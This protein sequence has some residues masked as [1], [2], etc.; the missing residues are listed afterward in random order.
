[1][2]AV[3]AELCRRN[4]HRYVERAWPL[5]EPGRPFVDNWHIGL[6]CEYLQAVYCDEIN[7]LIINVPPRH[8]KS[9]LVSVFFPTWSWISQPQLTWLTGSYASPLAVRDALKSR[10]LLQSDWY[11]T[12]FGAS[13]KM[14]GDQNL[15]SRYENDQGGSRLT[16]SFN[17]AVTGEGGDLLVV[18][19]PLRAQ[20]ADNAA[21]REKV[22][23]IYDQALT[24]RANNP[25]NPHRVIIMQRLHEQDL[26]GH[27]LERGAG[28]DAGERTQHLCLPAEYTPRLFLPLRG[29]ADARS[30]VGQPLWPARFGVAEMAAAKQNLGERGYAGQYNQRPYADGGSI[31]KASWWAGQNRFLLGKENGEG[32]GQV[33]GRWLSWDTALKDGE[34]NDASAMVVLELLPE[35]RLRLRHAQWGKYS[36]PQLARVVLDE[37][38]RWNYDGKLRGVIIEDKAS[39]ISAL[40]TLEQSAPAEIAEILIA[41]QPGQQSKAARARQASLWC[42]RGCV[43]L[44]EPHESVPW[45][46]DFEESLLKFPAARMNDPADAFTQAILYLENILAEGWRANIGGI[47]KH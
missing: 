42:E 15:K 18:D 13:F 5:V 34:Q 20:D 7:N 44:P 21:Q 46:F 39:G 3:E 24:T 19:D 17:S 35:Y 12:R 37:A 6:I 26:T 10:R 43:L 30:E 16:F 1:M 38:E 45:L 28:L 8:M 9:L 47:I 11:R 27:L 22:N 33:V 2:A 29:L 32:S 25:K 36:F 40:Q 31:Y 14:R 41:F 4:L 23:E